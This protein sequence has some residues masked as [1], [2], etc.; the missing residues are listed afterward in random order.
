M[1]VY[2]FLPKL[3]FKG[4]WILLFI[5]LKTITSVRRIFLREYCLLATFMPTLKYGFK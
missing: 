5:D 3:F 2:Y 4:G 1:K